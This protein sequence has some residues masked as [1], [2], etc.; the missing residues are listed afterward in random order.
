[1]F[2]LLLYPQPLYYHIDISEVDA[3]KYAFFFLLIA[4]GLTIAWWKT[5]TVVSA[6]V[7]NPEKPFSSF[8]QSAKAHRWASN[9]LESYNLL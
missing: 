7:L 2:V 8:Q 5:R 1:M 6:S 3:V 4:I 9:F